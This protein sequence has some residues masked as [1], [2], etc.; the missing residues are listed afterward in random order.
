MPAVDP[1]HDGPA[2]RLASLYRSHCEA[3]LRFLSRKVGRHEATDLMHEAFIRVARSE[4]ERTVF[5]NERAFLFQIAANLAVDHNRA[6]MRQSRL[7]TPVEIDDLL[8]V[9]DEGPGPDRQAQ[10]RL[11]LQRLGAAL[12]ELP[13]RRAEAFRL[14]RIEGLSHASIAARLGVSLRTVEAEVRMALD[15]CADR[16]RTGRIPD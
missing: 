8:A 6:Q 14:S 1:A 16:L 3:L 7:L 12:R 2:S 11:D 4:Q 10:G 5:H 15:H 13:P 9:A